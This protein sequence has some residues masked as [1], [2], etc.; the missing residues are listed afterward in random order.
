MAHTLYIVGIGPG[1]PDYVVPRARKRIDEASVL[2]GSERALADFQRPGQR[3]YSITGKLSLV[4]EAIEHELVDHDVVVMVSGDTGYYSLLPYLKKK[5]SHVPIQVE[6]GLSSITF[7]FSRLGEVWHNAALMS[8]HGRQPDKAQ[9]VY[10][11][12]KKMAFLTDPEYNP[13]HICKLLCE[14]DWP[15]DTKAAA[16]ERLSYDDER[17]ERGTLGSLQSLEGFGHSILVVLG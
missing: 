10:S 17:I 7:A 11:P 1:H 13:A 2:V 3:T 12:G 15:V 6:P 8:F 16:L 14:L 9:L 5:F 4:A